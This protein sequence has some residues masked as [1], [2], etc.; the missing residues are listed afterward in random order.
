MADRVLKI[1]V[2][3][4]SGYILFYF[5]YISVGK[6]SLLYQYVN[7]QFIST[8]KSTLGADF[9]LKQIMVDGQLVSLQV[10]Q[11]FY[12]VMGYCW[13]RKISSIRKCFL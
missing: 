4:D 11:L 8:F 7:H 3:G 6:T 10:F 13:S 12:L 2:L 9:L 1:I 5:I